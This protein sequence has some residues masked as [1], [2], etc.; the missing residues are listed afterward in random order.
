MLQHRNHELR[1]PQIVWIGSGVSVFKNISITLTTVDLLEER[2]RYSLLV[3]FFTL[4]V[5]YGQQEVAI[6]PQPKEVSLGAE[7]FEMNK[8]TRILLA[9]GEGLEFE[10]KFLQARMEE[11]IGLRLPISSK[12]KNAKGAIRLTFRKGDHP[13]EYRIRIDGSGVE[14]SAVT[15]EGIFHGIQS[16]IQVMNANHLENNETDEVNLPYLEVYDFP[17]FQWRGMH[18]DVC[19]HFFTTE[20]VKRYIDYLA[21][22]KMNT[23]HWHLTEDQGWRIEIKKYP[24]LTEVG[25]WRAGTMVGPYSNHEFDTIRYGGFYTQEQIKEV[26]AYA[27]DRHITVVPEIEMPG[28]ALAALAAYPDLSCTGGPFEVGQQWGVYDDVYC[29]GNEKVFEFLEDVLDEVVALFPG[30][31]V[32][33]GGDE[34]PKTRWEACE[35]CQ[36]RIATEGLKDE[37]ELQSYFIQRMERYLNGKGKKIIGWDEILEGGL[38]PNAAVMSWR[39]ESGGV[40]A[41]EAE[42]EVVMSPG[43]PCYFDHYQYDYIEGEP[44][45]IGGLNTLEAVYN[46]YPIPKELAAEKHKFILGAQANVWTEYIL[47]FAQVE[48]MALPRMAAIADALWRVPEQKNFDKFLKDLEKQVHLL[49]YWKTNYCTHFLN[50]V[51]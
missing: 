3:A 29:A 37:H 8:K 30:E 5:A 7:F 51:K 27:S 32:H 50:E 46:Y 24:L 9:P 6:I 22:Y 20:E 2:M 23:F 13:D 47:S 49:D 40:A 35:K 15:A 45:A 14:I 48:Y 43:R 12:T 41:A 31:F 28:H 18:L 11:L 4:F 19:R 44:L 21:L 34:C 33:I 39:G 42:H 1:I 38:A 10:A 26:V 16:L 25:A 17:N 36:H